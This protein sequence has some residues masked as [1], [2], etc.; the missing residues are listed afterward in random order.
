M[1]DAAVAAGP[2]SLAEL[3]VSRRGANGSFVSV[4]ARGGTPKRLTFAELFTQAT[5]AA[6]VL[7]RL[8]IERGDAESPPLGAAIALRDPLSFVLAFFA[9]TCA[10]WMPIPAPDRLRE[11][12]HH[13]RRLRQIV[14]ASRARYVITADHQRLEVAD[15]LDGLGVTVVLVED[16][17]APAGAGPDPFPSASGDPVAYIQYTSGSVSQP[18][19]IQVGQR[20]VLAHLRQAA[21]AYGESANSVSVNWIPLYHD[22]GLVTS[23]LRPLWS[24]YTS[25]LLDHFDFVRKPERWPAAMS[26]WRATHTSAPDFGYA[27]CASKVAH[28]RRFDLRSLRVARSAGE[29][30]RSGTIERFS[31]A[32]RPAGFD[33]AAFAP[34]Y[35]L[36][37]ATLTVTTCRPDQPPRTLC[38]SRSM[39]RNDTVAAPLG[40]SDT[41]RLVST[42]RPLDET[43]VR[44]LDADG[45][46]FPTQ[47][48]IG[49][50]WIAGP[51]VVVDGSSSEFDGQIG[52][53]TGDFGF[54]DDGELVPLGRSQERFQ[55]RG[56]NYYSSDVERLVVAADE[57]LRPGRAAAF[58][59]AR[60]TTDEPS[61][62]VLVELRADSGQ[63]HESDVGTIEQKIRLAAREQLG[64]SLGPVALVPA[65]TLPRTTSGKLRR[66]E[67]RA[68]AESG[69]DQWLQTPQWW[70]RVATASLSDDR[71]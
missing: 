69:L 51:Q 70:Q 58:P 7:E 26:E 54:V 66:D 63:L 19:P 35:G 68:L 2:T 22:M 20:Q 45:R 41:Q 27:L 71:R 18:K 47:R 13:R 46:P 53:R 29:M 10:G 61:I 4:P 37:E 11:F 60:C 57:R 38:V 34:S 6:R 49:E 1:Q 67:C 62:V 5:H 31:T 52:R 55:V 24:G 25:V 50:I 40:E 43:T 36:A 32:F 48:R 59:S 16:L 23:V 42:G 17:V 64:L 9:S 28:T 30:V 65:G 21:R 12:P 33:R 56:Q 14:T 8:T 3:L 15:S 39:L 44:I